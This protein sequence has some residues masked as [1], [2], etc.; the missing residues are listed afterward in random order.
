MESPRVWQE[1]FG[2]TPS[3]NHLSHQLDGRIIPRP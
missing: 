2:F 3:G 1:V